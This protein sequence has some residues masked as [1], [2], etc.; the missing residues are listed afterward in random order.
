MSVDSTGLLTVND[1]SISGD[2][3]IDSDLVVNTIQVNDSA[4]VT[5]NFTV[6]SDI[7][8]VDATYDRVGI[9]TTSPATALDV[10]GTVTADGLNLGDNEYIQLGA[11]NDLQIY[12]SGTNSFITETGTGDLNI[13][14]QNLSLADGAPNFN[15]YFRGIAG[16]DVRLYYNGLQKLST[17]STGVDVTGTVTVPTVYGGTAALPTFTLQNTSGN[18][19]HSKILIGNVV[20][21]DNGGLSFY[22][23]GTSVSTQRMRIFGI[24]GDIAFYDDAGTTPELYWDAS[25][26]NLGIGT[27]SPAT[28]LD[29]TGT[30]TADTFSFANWT[31][32]E[33]DGSLYFAT[34]GINKMK[35]D[36]DGNLDVVGSVNAN[37]TIS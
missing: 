14:A 16:Q 37:A 21:S 27:T 33:S 7:L 9:G 6:D 30:V 19:N 10:T 32:T 17:T 23:A 3:T 2:I 11:S 26:G 4:R 20:S 31:V 35:L 8:H 15:Y 34:G 28:A 13:N 29:V 22:S 18:A 5:G 36:S 1:I 25:A 24:S 12:N